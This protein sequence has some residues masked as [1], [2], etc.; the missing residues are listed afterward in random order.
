MSHRKILLLPKRGSCQESGRVARYLAQRARREK[1]SVCDVTCSLVQ[2]GMAVEQS[3]PCV[4]RLLSHWRALSCDQLALLD[5]TFENLFSPV[6]DGGFRVA[7]NSMA[8]RTDRE[9]PG[10]TE[11]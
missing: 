5:A 4:R 9:G 11:T 3:P 8:D 10:A 1:S 7:G 2:A 6:L